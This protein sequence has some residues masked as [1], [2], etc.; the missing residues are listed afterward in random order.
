MALDRLLC[1]YAEE[2]GNHI[3]DIAI[4]VVS[5]QI[6]TRTRPHYGGRLLASPIVIEKGKKKEKKKSVRWAL[7]MPLDVPLERD[8]EGVVNGVGLKGPSSV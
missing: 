4:E 2:N 7:N 6:H 5:R 8:L 1:A 3:V